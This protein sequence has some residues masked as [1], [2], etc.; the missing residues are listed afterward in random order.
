MVSPAHPGRAAVLAAGGAKFALRPAAIDRSDR[1]GSARR[2]G[3]RPAPRTESRPGMSARAGEHV[4]SDAYSHRGSPSVDGKAAAGG[5]A[6][7]Q[8]LFRWWSLTP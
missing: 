4:G 5:T 3:T 2:E 1:A 6:C 8:E 7:S